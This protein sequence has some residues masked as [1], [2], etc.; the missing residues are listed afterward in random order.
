[1]VTKGMGVSSS[2]SAISLPFATSDRRGSSGAGLPLSGACVVEV[3]CSFEAGGGENGVLEMDCPPPAVLMDEV[4]GCCCWNRKRGGVRGGSPSASRAPGSGGWGNAVSADSGSRASCPAG[5]RGA[6]A[7]GGSRLS[8]LDPGM[9]NVCATAAASWTARSVASAAEHWAQAEHS[10]CLRRS[11]T[12]TSPLMTTSRRFSSSAAS[13]RRL[14]QARC[15]CCSCCSR[16]R[17]SC[18][19]C[20][21]RHNSRAFTSSSQRQALAVR[22]ASPVAMRWPSSS[23]CK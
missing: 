4:K 8:A 1:M 9:S 7:S 17:R 21:W 18:S 14:N 10:S 16:L 5:T 23:C 2:S 3:L 20:F 19:A 11:R 12:V 22:S 6:L 13:A 15:S